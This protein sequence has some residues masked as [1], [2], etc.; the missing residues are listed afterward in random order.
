M[1]SCVTFTS[2][3]VPKPHDL[4]PKLPNYCHQGFGL[5][6]TKNTLKCGD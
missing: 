5:Q 6:D 4:L 3:L 1:V 2:S